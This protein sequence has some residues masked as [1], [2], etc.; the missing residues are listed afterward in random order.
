MSDNVIKAYNWAIKPNKFTGRKNWDDLK[1]SVDAAY[2]NPSKRTIMR[3]QQQ[4]GFC[5]TYWPTLSRWLIMG[6]PK[7]HEKIHPHK[8][9]VDYGEEHEMLVEFFRELTGTEPKVTDW[10]DAK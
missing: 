3:N 6:D 7:L 4:I 10:R 9:E 2:W 8:S 5:N 1:Q